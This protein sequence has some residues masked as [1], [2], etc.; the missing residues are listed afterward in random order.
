MK[1]N[2]KN[3]KNGYALDILKIGEHQILGAVNT[4]PDFWFPCTWA[5]DTGEL[6]AGPSIEGIEP[7]GF[8]L[9]EREDPPRVFY[10]NFDADGEE[11][12]SSTPTIFANREM[13][14][15]YATFERIACV[16]VQWRPG[17]GL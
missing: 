2:D 10:I 14:D 4:A 6:I 16:E 5:T 8:D 3:V 9:A 11:G 1:W 15:K 12:E 17:D 7:G 13:A